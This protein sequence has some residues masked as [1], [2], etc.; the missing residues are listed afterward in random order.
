M[1]SISNLID[2]IPKQNKFIYNLND[3]IPS[4]VTCLVNAMDPQR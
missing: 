3:P 2:Y 4:K 1:Q